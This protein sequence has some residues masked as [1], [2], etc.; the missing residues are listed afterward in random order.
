M[1]PKMSEGEKRGRG[2]PVA[3]D[4]YTALHE[5]MKLFWERGY[6]G[7]SFD[8]LIGAMSISA[9]TF[10]NSFGSKERLYDEAV[11]QYLTETSTW[12]SRI[13]NEPGDTRAV[14]ERLF[15]STAEEFTRPDLPAGC[16][17]ALAGTHVSP[18]LCSIREKMVSHRALSEV[19]MADR[20][21]RGISAGDVAPDTNVEVLAGFFSALS[22]G[23]AVEARDGASK[24]RLLQIGRQAMQVWP[25][26]PKQQGQRVSAGPHRKAKA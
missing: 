17:I 15:E 8:D 24:E 2:R 3:F 18:S 25:A 10:Y 26:G 5:A 22:R 19:V 1:I 13:L 4:R 20:L 14:F 23:L 7:T 9:S 12:F 6:E 11:G 16:M 21:R